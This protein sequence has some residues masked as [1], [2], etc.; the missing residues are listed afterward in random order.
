MPQSA[1]DDK[2]RALRQYN[3]LNPHPERVRDESFLSNTFFDPRDLVQV[4]YEMLRRVR[5][6]GLTVSESAARFGM[7]RPTWYQAQRAWQAGGL[8]AL[9]PDT[10]SE[11]R[12]ASPHD[13]QPDR[14][15]P[16]SV[17]PHGP[18]AQHRAR[19]G[20]AKKN[21]MIRRDV[22]SVAGSAG[23]DRDYEQLRRH[24]VERRGGGGDT[25]SEERAASP[26]DC[27][28]DRAA[29]RSVWPHGP[30]AQ[31]RARTGAAKKNPMIRRDVTS[32]AGSAGRDR[33][34]EQHAVTRSSRGQ[35]SGCTASPFWPTAASPLGWPA[36]N[37]PVTPRPRGSGLGPNQPRRWRWFRLSTF[38]SP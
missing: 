11:E 34:Y 2:V 14:A 12:A 15:A 3:S 33:D 24:A 23:R 18:S 35:A 31:H 20:A 4:K 30:S 6:D 25:D 10:D 21:P 38:C 5:K 17:W 1:S 8:P 13:C 7:S 27:Q 32:V 36:S 37:P 19:T 16:R 29:P 22:T 26:H 28:P 9:L